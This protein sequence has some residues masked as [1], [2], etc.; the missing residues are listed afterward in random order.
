MADF[1]ASLEEF[2]IDRL[3]DPAGAD[4]AF[5][6]AQPPV[7]ERLQD[8]AFARQN[9]HANA[10][11]FE[12]AL[13]QIARA[14]ADQVQ[15]LRKL[16]LALEDEYLAPGLQPVGP[17][18]FPRFQDDRVGNL[19]AQIGSA[20]RFPELD[21]ADHRNAQREAEFMGLFLVKQRRHHRRVRHGHSTG[22][23]PAA[24]KING[25][26]GAFAA[27]NH[28]VK[29][30]RAEHVDKPGDPARRVIG[31]GG[32][33]MDLSD[34]SGG[35]GGRVRIKRNGMNLH[36]GAPERARDGEENPHV[37]TDDKDLFLRAGF[38]LH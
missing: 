12:I 22:G 9:R 31:N 2:R 35:Q 7:L 1:R 26:D 23:E 25:D 30:V 20:R 28:Q 33:M 5:A 4:P 36:A 27:W 34:I 15:G 11:T 29:T 18:G 14:V 24:V 10:F 6:F 38:H 37:V 17:V 3:A 21:L 16:C 32:K 19:A 13:R 8:P